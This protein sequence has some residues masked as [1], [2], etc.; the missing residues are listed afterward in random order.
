MI[1]NFSLI[2]EVRSDVSRTQDGEGNTVRRRDSS[3]EAESFF[4]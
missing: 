1:F 4:R 3:G 2:R